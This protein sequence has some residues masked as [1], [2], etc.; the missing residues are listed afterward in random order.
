MLNRKSTLFVFILLTLTVIMIYTYSCPA[1]TFDYQTILGF[2]EGEFMPGNNLTLILNFRMLGNE[3][4]TGQIVLFQ[5]NVQIQNDPLKDV[6]LKDNILSFYIEAK[7]TRFNGSLETGGQEIT[8][9][10]HFPDGTVHPLLVRKVAAPSLR[11]YT[12]NRSEPNGHDILERKYSG[13][14]LQ[15]DL[16]FLRDQ[17]E[18][19]HPQLY[20]YS[21]KEKFDA[22]FDSTFLTINDEMTED[23]FFR[24]MAVIV[25]KVNCSHTGIRFSREFSRALE[26][27]KNL[28]PLDI[29]FIESKAYIIADYSHNPAVEAGMQLL[30][31]NGIP[32]SEVM[33]KLNASIP[34]DG[35]NESLKRHEINSQFARLY[36]QYI[37]NYER[38]DLECATDAGRKIRI[39]LPAMTQEM[40][41]S[42]IRQAHPER[43]GIDSS[44][45][46]I[47]V[48]NETS[49]AVLTVKS[50]GA[51]DP[52]RYNAFLRESFARMRTE[53][54]RHLI[55]DVRGNKGG[56]PFFAAE[57][58]SYLARSDFVYF[59][60]PLEQGELTSLYQ[61][62]QPKEH[63]FSGDI[64]I[65]I[66]GGCLSSTGHFLSLVRFH[67]MA[68]LIGEEPGGSF[69]CND[70]SKQRVLPN[71]K[72]ELNLPQLTFQT[73][74]TGFEKGDPLLPDHDV[75]PSLEDFLSGRDAVMEYTMRLIEMS[76][77]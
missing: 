47:E 52:E 51:P 63:A 57:L 61:P 13:A 6:L 18:N 1:A 77:R 21:S 20:L 50:F 42:A 58:L 22:L 29:R 59:K 4:V 62:I 12:L 23:E 72:I 66:N 7:N 55:I 75:K 33:R 67:K 49:I 10:F 73:A 43:T 28:I 68:I 35:F 15:D 16:T 45:L 74:V 26:S 64:Y 44:P 60:R 5:G 27:R 30:S 76:V 19:T 69:Y 36:S 71:T 40:L 56:H 38:F 25:A 8:G 70:G 9:D 24:R 48:N 41:D 53:G 11:E 39:Q 31:I 17:L 3:T 65:L 54:I 37:G 34:S 32:S 2:W 14:Q 46:E